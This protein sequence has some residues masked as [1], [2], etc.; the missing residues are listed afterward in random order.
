MRRALLGFVLLIALALQQLPAALAGSRT[1]AGVPRFEPAECPFPADWV[2]IGERVECGYLVVL[3]DRIQPTG[4]TLRLAVAILKSYGAD[5]VPDPVV[6]LSGGPG[7]P[8]LAGVNFWLTRDRS[9]RARRDL[10]LIDQRGTGYSEPDMRCPELNR[11]VELND[12]GSRPLEAVTEVYVSAALE[13]RDRL[14]AE[15]VNLAAYNSSASAADLADLRRVLG[16]AEWNL[17]GLS[18]GGRLVLTTLR[19]QPDGIR[20]AILDSPRTVGVRNYEVRPAD[21]AHAFQVLFDGC[22][23]DPAC[24]DA[25]PSL[26]RSFD[27]LVERLNA[28]PVTVTVVDGTG[29]SRQVIDGNQVIGGG[30]QALYN[31]TLIPYLPLAIDQIHRGNYD[32]LAGFASALGQGSGG[33]AGMGYSVR[34]H[35]E[36]P[37]ND[38]ARVQAEIERYPR[39]RS[40]F[41]P[42]IL[43]EFDICAAWGAG[44]APAAAAE[45]VRSDI[46][47]LILTGEYDPIHPRWWGQLAADH[48]S[49]SYHYTLPGYGHGVSFVGECQTG[50]RDSFLDDPARPP[51]AACLDDLPPPA[52]VTDVYIQGG[53]LTFALALQKPDAVELGLLGLIFLVFLSALAGWPLAHFIHQ[54]RSGY[55]ASGR[56]GLA[57]AA[58]WLA[59]L[60]ILLDFAFILG[61][62]TVIIDVARTDETVLVFGVPPSAAWLFVLP[63]VVTALTVALAIA[64]LWAWRQGY[65]SLTS[66]LHFSLVSLAAAGLVGLLAWWGLLRL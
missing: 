14:W 6:F 3:E 11:P 31:E 9:L 54:R 45:P 16:Y 1:Q 65:W 62:V 36:I 35:E 41:G 8:N 48:L 55:A 44:T 28:H 2:P 51:D 37:F 30:F 63:P 20:S 10:I 61:L 32:V 33:S 53:V 39:L 60:V 49:R 34:C 24:R 21:T 43:P 42:N 66:R 4:R 59:A 15:G 17:Y 23:A 46:P 50:L 40:Y 64:G 27:E 18:Y 26:E 7:G 25:F 29:R 57:V 12:Q 47:T 22:G 56:V 58:R 13:C 38:P 5:P 52:F 19:E